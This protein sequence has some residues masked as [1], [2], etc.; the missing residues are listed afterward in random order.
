VAR[1]GVRALQADPHALQEEILQSARRLL[2]CDVVVILEWDRARDLVRPRGGA[3][4]EGGLTARPVLAGDPLLALLGGGRLAV[5]DWDASPSSALREGAARSTLAAALSPRGEQLG[6]LTAHCARPRS[7]TADQLDTLQALATLLAGSG[8]R[9]RIADEMLWR[10]LH[11]PLTEL[12]NRALFV[13][14]LS[15]AIAG[16]E[17]S[18]RAVAVMFLDLDHFKFVNDSLGHTAGDELLRGVAARLAG[19]MREHDTVARF[20]GDEFLLICEDLGAGEEAAEIAERV[21][22]AVA[23]PIQLAGNEH[24]VTVSLGI[25]V[26]AGAHR[27]PEDLIR[28][29][30]AAMYEAKERGR[31]GFAVYDE[32]MRARASRRLNVEHQLRRAIEGGELRLSYQPVFSLPER[33]VVGVE[34]LVRWQHPELGLIMPDD[35]MTVAEQSG[36]IIPL[37]GW[38]LHEAISQAAAWRRLFPRRHLPVSVNLSPREFTDRELYR[39]VRDLLEDHGVPAEMIELE[40]TESVLMDPAQTSLESL[41]ALREMG[42][43][44]VLDDFGT[45]YSSLSYVKHFPI[46]GLKIDRGFVREM[47]AASADASIVEAVVSMARGLGLG[48]VA[49]GVETVEQAELLEDLGCVRCQGFS[50]APAVTAQRVEQLLAAEIVKDV[51]R[52]FLTAG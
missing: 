36:L 35:F 44:I 41:R 6:I 38:V 28:E 11:D 40:I 33:Q 13:D 47:V 5:A 8:E 22:A 51:R 50:F 14:R 15:H 7:F 42:V 49:E 48:V 24:V 20:G 3:E 12:P 29:A 10:A 4:A 26:A 16:C 18:G 1:L 31:N 52:G 19:C 37:G 32:A 17:R 27:H 21:I 25:S 46:D 43:R 39:K 45:G 34:A 30:D 2:D 23:Q 9:A